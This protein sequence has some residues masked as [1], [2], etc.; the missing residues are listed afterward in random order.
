MST[1]DAKE[2]DNKTI[3][4]GSV[5]HVGQMFFDQALISQVEKL[6]PY[7]TNKQQLTTNANDMIMKQEAENVDPVIE[8]V[9]VGDN[10][11]DGIFGWLAFGINIDA[12]YNVSAA[13]TLTGNGGTENAGSGG[14]NPGGEARTSGAASTGTLPAASRS[15]VSSTLA[16]TVSL[17]A[18]TSLAGKIV[19]SSYD[20][21]SAT[22]ANSDKKTVWN[23]W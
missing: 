20:A 19:P 3:T 5:A 22:C 23:W 10:I 11:S 17:S 4:G 16:V 14:R 8:Y 21:S 15:A 9:F 12:S 2:N 1:L 6:A 7:T 18:A 13:A